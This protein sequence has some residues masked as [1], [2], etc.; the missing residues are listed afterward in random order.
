MSP[1]VAARLVPLLAALLAFG[2]RTPLPA[3]APLS[4]DD[5]RPGALL[6]ALVEQASRV[7]AVRG[8]ARVSIEGQRGSAFAKQIVLMQ[9]P[10]KLRVEVMGLLNQRV[11]VLAT[12]GDRYQLYRAESGLESGDVRPSVLF[13]VAGL[14]LPP[15][16]AVALIL[17]GPRPGPDGWHP[18]P[19]AIL[20]E[21]G[22]RVQLAGDAEQARRSFEFDAEGNLRRYQVQAPGTGDLL[23]DVRYEDVRTVVDT[24]FAHS[25]GLDFPTLGTSAQVSFREIELNP[26]L[27]A[28]LFRLELPAS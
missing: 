27:P 10:A 11:A 15:R 28:A 2:C 20:A 25:I 7:R 6:E 1:R 19:A 12:D 4:P 23:L 26:E 14:P 17:G 24:D 9:R 22:I 13:E 16:E 18:G 8:T 21:G 5:P 3:V